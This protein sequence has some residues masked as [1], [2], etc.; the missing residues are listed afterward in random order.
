MT[1]AFLQTPWESIHNECYRH[2]GVASVYSGGKRDKGKEKKRDRI[3]DTILRF[4]SVMNRPTPPRTK[5][6]AVRAV[7][8]ITALLLS[9][10]FRQL[11]VMVVE[12]LWDR[13]KAEEASFK[14]TVRE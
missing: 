4:R 12:W 8:G 3:T 7:G 14:V 13:L 10:L 1:A 6:D 11:A 2:F 5:Q 9:Y